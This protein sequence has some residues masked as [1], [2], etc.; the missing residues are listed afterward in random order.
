MVPGCGFPYPLKTSWV[1]R[2]TTLSEV[3][4]V[5]EPDGPFPMEGMR[6]APPG[7]VH[8]GFI[9]QISS[10]SRIKVQTD[11]S[12]ENTGH[13]SGIK[14]SFYFY[15]LNPLLNPFPHT[16]NLQQTTLNVFCQKVENLHN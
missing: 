11:G 16:A 10:G 12:P 4:G 2:G 13:L 3:G 7:S 14:Y 9:Q 1:P 15:I 6:V 5:P 8:S